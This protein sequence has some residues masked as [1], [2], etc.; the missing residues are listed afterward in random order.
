MIRRRGL[1]PAPAG[2]G[3]GVAGSLDGAGGVA[4]VFT[5]VAIT[6]PSQVL[7]G[8]GPR[9]VARPGVAVVRTGRLHFGHFPETRNGVGMRLP[10]LAENQPVP[11]MRIF[12]V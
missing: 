9:H 12:H 3:G 10:P 5:R 8:H 7:S 4:L 11:Y 6:R 1:A 2:A